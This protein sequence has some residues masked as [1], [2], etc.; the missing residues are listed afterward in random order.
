MNTS[1]TNE[2]HDFLL[3]GELPT[4]EQKRR[5]IRRVAPNYRLKDNRLFYTG[6]SMQSMRLL[7]MSEEEKKPVLMECHN[8]PGTGNHNGVRGTRNMVVAGFYWPTLNQDISEWG[9]LDILFGIRLS[10]QMLSSL[11]DE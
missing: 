10:G 4:I 1:E 7:V 2:I 8:N 11:P 3:N 5:K 9:F 6:P